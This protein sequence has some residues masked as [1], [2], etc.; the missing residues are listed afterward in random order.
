VLNLFNAF[1][2][3]KLYV[4]ATQ[5]ANFSQVSIQVRTFQPIIYGLGLGTASGVFAGVARLM[6]IHYQEQ[7][8]NERL[9]KL[10]ILTEL[11][12]IK[13][14]FHPH[15]LSDALQNISHLIRNHSAK[16]PDAILKLADLLSYFLYEN[17][18]EHVPLAQ[19]IQMVD[20]YLELEKIFYDDR[21]VIDIKKSGEEN[22]IQIA[23][24]IILGIV[25]HCCEQSLLS[26]QQKLVVEIDLKIQ[27]NQLEFLLHCNGYFESINGTLHQSAG[28][29]QAMKRVEVL[30][31]GTHQME[32]QLNNGMFSFKLFLESENIHPIPIE[33]AEMK[34]SYAAT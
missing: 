8:E 20:A 10:K 15:F 17:E 23:P 32:S 26:L 6:K 30:Y 18:K 3:T 13:T 19:E 16:A 21:I 28:L 33:K 22:D 29:K 24:L 5:K 27:R 34:L 7:K 31:S 11:E 14:H 25:Q 2:I 4:L 9:E 12:I 1:W